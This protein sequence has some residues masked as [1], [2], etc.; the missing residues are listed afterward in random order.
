MLFQWVLTAIL[1]SSAMGLTC[2][3]SVLEGLITQK[4]R[5]EGKVVTEQHWMPM[6]S[7]FSI[8]T[9]N[10]TE[11]RLKDYSEDATII[12]KW[13]NLKT[14]KVSLKN[15]TSQGYNFSKSFDLYVGKTKE[16][17]LEISSAK[18]NLCLHKIQIIGGD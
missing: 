17:E 16:L 13:G 3:P 10:V 18:K 9:G 5:V 1:S 8:N 2:G 15:G 7:K 12:L 14:E 4:K 6:P 11:L